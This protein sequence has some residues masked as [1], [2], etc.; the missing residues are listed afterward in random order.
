MRSLPLIVTLAALLAIAPWAAP[1]AAQGDQR[2]FPETGQCIAGPIRAYWLRPA[3][4]SRLAMGSTLS[5]VGS[6][7]WPQRRS[8]GRKRCRYS[9]YALGLSPPSS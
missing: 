5:T 1:A 7:W 9:R 8:L 3:S 6:P 4:R 2:C